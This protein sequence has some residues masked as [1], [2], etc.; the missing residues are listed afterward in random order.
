MVEDRS[1]ESY[2][3]VLAITS[4]MN[5]FNNSWILDLS[6]SC[7]MCLSRDWFDTYEPFNHGFILM[8]NN[9][10]YKT[11]GIETIKFKM[12]DGIVQTLND[13]RYVLDLKKNLISLRALNLSGWK[14]SVEG[15]MLKVINGIMV[16]MK[17]LKAGNLYKLIKSVAISGATIII[18]D[19]G[20]ID[21]VDLWH[22]RLRHMC[23][24]DMFE[25][26][27]G[28][29]WHASRLTNLVSISISY[30]QCKVKF[31]TGGS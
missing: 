6:C 26:Q 29:N 18:D 12:F 3:N 20:I 27:K 2:A 16:V 8:G 4:S 14:Y 11:I 31:C 23:K 7:H 21:D 22:I 13:V 24:H 5:Y 10:P 25:L 17:S 1:N 15:G 9:A 28:N 19:E 30:K